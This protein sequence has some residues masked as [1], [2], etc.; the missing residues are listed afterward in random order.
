SFTLSV[1][2]TDSYQF[3]ASKSYSLTVQSAVQLQTSVGNLAFSAGAAGD[4]P[5]PQ[6]FLVTTADQSATGFSVQLDGGSPNTPPPAW[7]SAQ[8]RSGVT[9][10]RVSVS[11]NSASLSTAAYSARVLI[12]GADGTQTIVLPV[13]FTLDPRAPTLEVVPNYLRLTA[14][15]QLTE[16]T[17]TTVLIHNVGG[18]G[19]INFQASVSDSKWLAV[20][21]ASGGAS[22][23]S[24][25]VLRVTANAAGLRRDAYRGVLRIASNAGNVDVPVAFVLPDSGPALALSANGIRF[26]A[27]Q[28]QGA[29]NTQ[30]VSILNV[31][32]STAHWTADLLGGQEW[33]SLGAPSGESTV[34][35]PGSLSISANPGALTSGAYYAMIRISDPNA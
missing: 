9:P 26:D 29:G 14:P 11:V 16:P 12:V 32:D 10:A 5:A 18:G 33:L 24:Y 13:T 7:I 22:T 15:G 19:S 30:T 21:P 20:Q 27:R 17:Q 35:T 2:V 25:T 6:S 1:K 28:A 4:S 8:P 23:D 31:G 3:S 34:D